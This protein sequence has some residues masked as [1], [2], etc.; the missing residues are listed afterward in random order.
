MSDEVKIRIQA[1]DQ[2]INVKGFVRAQ[3]RKHPFLGCRQVRCLKHK[4]AVAAPSDSDDSGGVRAKRMSVGSAS[5]TSSH[6]ATSAAPC[7][8]K[9][10]GPQ[11]S[12][13]VTLPGGTA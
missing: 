5:Q 1:L 11:D 9:V 8:I 12:L 2:L 3:Q 7:F 10:L 13:L 4:D 6:V